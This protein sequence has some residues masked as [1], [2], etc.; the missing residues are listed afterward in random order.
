MT[1]DA[2]LLI[3]GGLVLL[4]GGGEFLVRGA[5][6]FAELLG[7][8]PL[9]VGLT[10][11][12]YG[13]SAPELAVSIQAGF[14][15]NDN[16]AVANVVGSN[17]F[18]VL[19]ILGLCALVAPLVVDRRLVRVDVPVMMAVSLVAGLMALDG[20]FAFWEGL[21]L[22]LG[23]ASYTAWSVISSRAE[24]AAAAAAAAAANSHHV[25]EPELIEGKHPGWLVS[26][27][28]I[29][30]L[31]G[32]G[33]KLGWFGFTQGGLALLGGFVFTLGHFF[34]KGGTTRAGDLLHQIGF[35]FT[36]LGV[37]VLGA[38][39]LVDGSVLTARALGVSDAVIGL[40]IVAAGT[41]L[42]EVA[43]SVVAT[44]R[45]ERDMAIGNVVGSNIAN[46][47]AILGISS[48]VT[49]G[50]LSV[51]ESLL[52]V[53]IPVMIAVAIVC[54]PVFY[55]GYLIRRWEGSVFLA[56]YIG[57][58]TWLVFDATKQ[59]ASTA[60]GEAL[61]WVFAPVVMATFAVTGMRAF[62]TRHH[63]NPVA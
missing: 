36:G 46:I 38:G 47:L 28:V 9:V 22:A 29:A 15:G 6:R 27:L 31:G 62:T 53:D 12:A 61:G 44:L 55:T 18:N 7:L 26:Q 60:L 30:A 54:L 59:P 1:L 34:G 20:N 40:T 3:L 41:S 50:G 58:T 5:S 45:G 17:I 4:V 42:P 14:A 33:W 23:T 43:A 63:N 10:V 51:A 49:P 11:V 24:T 16:I 57:Y 2:F 13:T 56:A 25:P 32:L 19:F 35:I 52:R 21:I 48:L 37:L 8:S 39:W